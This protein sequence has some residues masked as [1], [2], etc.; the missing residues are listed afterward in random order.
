MKKAVDPSFKWINPDGTPTQYFAELI[1]NL[2]ANGLQ[3]KVSVTAPT[4]GQ[5]MLFN[6]TTGLWTPG[7]N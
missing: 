1:Q 7:A 2:S 4:N 5:V 6:A 3:N